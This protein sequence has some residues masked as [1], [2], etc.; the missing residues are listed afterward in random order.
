[1]NSLYKPPY[2]EL[3]ARYLLNIYKYKTFVRAFLPPIRMTYIQIGIGDTFGRKALKA[4][5]AAKTVKSEKSNNANHCAKACKNSHY[6]IDVWE[7]KKWMVHG[8]MDGVVDGPPLG[9]GQWLA[10][11]MYVYSTSR[12]ELKGYVVLSLHLFKGQLFTQMLIINAHTFF[13]SFPNH[14][15]NFCFFFFVPTCYIVFNF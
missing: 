9:Y 8:W 14:F 13:L 12:L 10:Y 3:E 4:L 11:T 1:M 6:I 15:I 7:H 2:K 5:K